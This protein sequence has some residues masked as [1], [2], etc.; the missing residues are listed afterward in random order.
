MS[1]E[2]TEEDVEKVVNYLK[3]YH[4]ENA[5]KDYAF[6]MLDYLKSSIHQLGINDVDKLEELY[7]KFKLK[8][9]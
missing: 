7:E 4:P 8:S 6:A 1:Y 5:N 9:Q 2:I 3:I